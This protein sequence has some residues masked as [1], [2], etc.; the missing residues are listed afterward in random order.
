MTLEGHVSETCAALFTEV[1]RG[2][3]VSFG[4][5]AISYTETVDVAVGQ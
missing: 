4:A 2:A 5:D 1:V 3:E